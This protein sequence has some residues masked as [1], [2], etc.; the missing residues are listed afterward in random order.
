MANEG[1]T[2]PWKES[3][4]QSAGPSLQA[5]PQSLGGATQQTV[6]SPLPYTNVLCWGFPKRE[7]TSA[8]L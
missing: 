4:S 2:L 1:W 7:P 3:W 6:S 5:L 8:G